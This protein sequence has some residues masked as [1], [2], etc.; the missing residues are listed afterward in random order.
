MKKFVIY[1]TLT[2]IFVF[3]ICYSYNRYTKI[4]Q[5]MQESTSRAYIDYM[6]DENDVKAMTYENFVKSDYI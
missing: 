5:N 4:Y 2:V 3:G 6:K 1:I